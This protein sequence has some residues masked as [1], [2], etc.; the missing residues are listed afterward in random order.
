MDSSSQECERGSGQVKPPIPYIS[1]KDDLQEVV[2]STAT[3]KLTLPTKVELRVS[4][5]VIR[6]RHRE[7]LAP[8]K[9]AI[10][11]VKAQEA[12]NDLCKLR[13]SAQKLEEAVFDH[14][15]KAGRL[16]SGY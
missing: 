6:S 1:E 7:V 8:N 16:L 3:I 9:P 5:V 14:F 15:Q 13:R 11:A 2:E 12:Y 4:V 10:K